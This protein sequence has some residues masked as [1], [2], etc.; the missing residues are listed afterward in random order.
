[1][2]NGFYVWDT[3]HNINQGHFMNKSAAKDK[4]ARLNK[5]GYEFNY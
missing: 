4:A 2:L 1:M 3:W 5:Y